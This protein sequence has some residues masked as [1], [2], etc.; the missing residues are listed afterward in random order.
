[1]RRLDKDSSGYVRQFREIALGERTPFAL[2]LDRWMK[3]RESYASHSVI[4][5]DRA[6]LNNFG[7]YLADVQDAP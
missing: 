1:M 5:L 2:V 7:H 6:T 3:D 4:S